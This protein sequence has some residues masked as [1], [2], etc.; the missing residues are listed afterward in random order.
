MLPLIFI[1]LLIKLMYKVILNIIIF[2]Y[3]YIYICEEIE[4]K[5]TAV[6]LADKCWELVEFHSK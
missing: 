5:N 2:A 4:R 1:N 6:D 3:I